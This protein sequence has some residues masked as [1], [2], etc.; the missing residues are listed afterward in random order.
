MTLAQL[1]E[2][3]EYT[4]LSGASDREVSGISRDNRTA[5]Q[6]DL[7][8]CTAGARFD[9]HAPDVVN[10][11]YEQ[12]VRAFVSEKALDLPEDAAVA[13]VENTRSAGAA[14]YAAWYGHPADDLTVIG[15]TG[16][17]GKTTTTH[18]LADILREGGHRV[19][20]IGTNGAIIGTEV[21]ELK[22][23]TPESDELE[24]YLR[25]MA[26]RGC[27]TVVLEISSQGMKQ[28][29]AD[30]FR[31]DYAVWLNLQE[32]D[33]IGPNEHE[34]F[35]DYA[36][37]KAEL[38]NH[39]ALGFVHIDDPF[40]EKFLSYVQEM[41]LITFGASE[42]AD[43]RAEDIA[44]TYDEAS[45][46]PGVR[47]TVSGKLSMDSWTNFPGEFNV[48]NA[49]A[50]IAVA[51]EMGVPDEA[52]NRALGNVHIK[53]RDDIVYKGP[54]FSVCVDFAH[55]GASTW[56]HL[57]ALREF[58]P[59]RLVCIFGAD[60]NRTVERRY[61][62]GEAAGKLADFSIVTSGHNRWETFEQILA[63]T[64]IG[65]NRAENPNYIAIKDRKTAIRYA[66]D[67]AEKGDL[68]TIIGLG[69]ENWQEEMGVKYEYS[70]TEFVKSVLREKGLIE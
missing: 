25:E 58:R 57:T 41:P 68:I 69:H 50:A 19:G 5:K 7:F 33:H 6:G 52:V 39:S 63:D 36:F 59:K 20:T 64:E 56:N 2:R 45:G 48:W 34:S 47:F 37:C 62:M 4:M 15:I 21:R 44:K 51:H 66:I 17:K 12:G 70:D 13:L 1:L 16:S 24:G 27:D 30:G 10:A 46:Q 3:T 32:G 53:G 29:R 8:I 49:L 42:G 31:F 54:D 65:L 35:E 61:G 23:T 18:M 28:H 43:Y 38:L 40:A 60:G 14:A 9:T 26:D 11:L 22:N 67:H 55:N